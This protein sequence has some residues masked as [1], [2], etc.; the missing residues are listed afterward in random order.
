MLISYDG[1]GAYM[2]CVGIEDRLARQ[3][4]D[5]EMRVCSELRGFS[6]AYARFPRSEL[7]SKAPALSLHRRTVCIRALAHKEGKVRLGMD[8]K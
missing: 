6:R 2:V 1:T 4:V 3:A 8:G 7:R 5:L